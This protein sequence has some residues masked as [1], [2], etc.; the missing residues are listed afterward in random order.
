M[1]KNTRTMEEN[2]VEPNVDF[3]DPSELETLEIAEMDAPMTKLEMVTPPVAPA[4][5]VT[6]EKRPKESVTI[7]CLRNEKVI[8]RFIPHPNLMADNPRHVLYGGMAETSVRYYTVPLLSN[9]SYKNV[10]TNSEKNFLEQ[11][12]GLEYN[13]L[14][15]YNKTN[16]F[17]ENFRVRLTKQDNIL[18][19][20]VPEDYIKYKV[21]LANTDYIAPSL[22]VLQDRPKNTYQYVIVSDADEENEVNSRVSSKMRCYMEFGKINENRRALVTVIRLMSGKVM[23]KSVKTSTLQG[24]VHD[25]I[26]KDPKTF[27]SVITD[28]LFATKATVLAAVENGLVVIRGDQYY[29]KDGN[30]PMCGDNTDPTLSNAARW[31]NLPKNNNVYMQLQI[32]T[33]D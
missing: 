10:L 27:L 14:G 1:A 11:V 25:I 24:M 17:W 28:P 33:K 2:T 20:S 29:L 18:D 13:A 8:V 30:V 31:L 21:L 15:V 6:Q 22:E 26:E 9:G 16:N 4:P 19:L 7:N 3:I 12:M 5:I 32:M 23:A